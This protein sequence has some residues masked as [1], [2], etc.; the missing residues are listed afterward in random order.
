M[1]A[2]LTIPASYQALAQL[3]P[4][5]ESVTTRASPH[6]Q[7]QL[8]L[9]VH[10]LCVNIIQHAYAG[11]PGEITLY[12]E[13]DARGLYLSIYD[14]APNIYQKVEH[15]SPDPLSLPESGWGLVILYRTMDHVSYVQQPDCNAWHLAKMWDR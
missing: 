8:A 13:Y 11:A 7:S 10:E 5:M 1:Y 9:A 15:L 2:T 3:T 4:F 12:A 6:L 14:T